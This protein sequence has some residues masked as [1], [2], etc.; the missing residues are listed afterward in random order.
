MYPFD[1]VKQLTFAD[2][3]TYSAE[4]CSGPFTP[5]APEPDLEKYGRANRIVSLRCYW[6]DN[7]VC[8]P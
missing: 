5:D 8:N 1:K 4:D 6:N 7:M 2:I 3:V